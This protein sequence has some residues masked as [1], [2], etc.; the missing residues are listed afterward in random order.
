MTNAELRAAIERTTV[1]GYD[2]TGSTFSFCP[3]PPAVVAEIKRLALAGLDVR[4]RGGV[5]LGLGGVRG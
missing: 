3:W 2:E 4:E 5:Q 1:A